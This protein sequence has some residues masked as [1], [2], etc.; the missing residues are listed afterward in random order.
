[1]RGGL[2]LKGFLSYDFE[3]EYIFKFPLGFYGLLLDAI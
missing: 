2:K 3:L 1:M